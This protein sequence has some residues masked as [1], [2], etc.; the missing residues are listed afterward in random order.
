MNR[1]PE[2]TLSPS[3]VVA[4]SALTSQPFEMGAFLAEQMADRY[5]RSAIF[6]TE[7]TREAYEIGVAV[8]RAQKVD[9]Q[10]GREERLAGYTPETRAKIERW[11]AEGCPF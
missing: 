1:I 11:E 8:G 6:W 9:E 7:A 10:I 4:L 3:D 2:I 5:E